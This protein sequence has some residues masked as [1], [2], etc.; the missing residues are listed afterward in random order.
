MIRVERATA[1]LTVTITDDGNGFDPTTAPT[2]QGLTNMHDRIGAIGGTLTL[3][4]T[5]GT[6]TTIHATIHTEDGTSQPAGRRDLHI[7][8]RVRPAAAR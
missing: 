2:G 1:A 4:T 5:P 7:A 8:R 6:G 3:H